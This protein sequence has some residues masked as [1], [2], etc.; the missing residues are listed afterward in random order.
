LRNEAGDGLEHIDNSADTGKST[1]IGFAIH[2][3]N[4]R[5]AVHVLE[6]SARD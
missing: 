6:I 4:A 1:K 3:N 2:A 5:F